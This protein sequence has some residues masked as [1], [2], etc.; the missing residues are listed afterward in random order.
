MCVEGISE[1]AKISLQ[2]RLKRQKVRLE[3]RVR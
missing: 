2:L 3:S 1:V